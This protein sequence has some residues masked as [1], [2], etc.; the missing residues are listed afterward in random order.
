MLL[1]LLTGLLLAGCAAREE[2]EGDPVE[3]TVM[4]QEDAPEELKKQM[5]EK[6]QEGFHLT[7]E[8]EGWLYVA[9]GYGAHAGGGYSVQV[10][11]CR[12]TEKAIY[13]HTTL[14]GPDSG[15]ARGGADTYPGIVLKM[16]ARD[17]QV[18]FQ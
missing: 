15:D 2:P 12:E 11:A 8:D 4:T 5:E 9:V 3:F 18:V 10:C 7:Y 17:K 6:C 16:E 13:V 14:L 1:L